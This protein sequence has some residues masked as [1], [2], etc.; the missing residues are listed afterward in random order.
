M[1]TRR[2]T[3][4]D[5]AQRRVRDEVD[6]R[7]AAGLGDKVGEHA[8]EDGVA[9]QGDNTGVRKEDAEVQQAEDSVSA[10]SSDESEG[11]DVSE[12]N[13]LMGKLRKKKQLATELHRQHRGVHADEACPNGGMAKGQYRRGGPQNQG[14][15]HDED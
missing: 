8:G 1:D 12:G 10:G 5:S 15:F 2:W 6:R 14:P 3:R 13:G 11:G 4:N 7:E 9:A